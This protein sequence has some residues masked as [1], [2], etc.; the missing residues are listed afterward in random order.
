LLNVGRS[1]LASLGNEYRVIAPQPPLLVTDAEHCDYNTGERLMHVAYTFENLSLRR[2]LLPIWHM[3]H[4]IIK[5]RLSQLG[6]LPTLDIEFPPS[7][8]FGFR[9]HFS[10]VCSTT[11]VKLF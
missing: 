7:L 2:K 10:S 4:D 9:F 1:L 11:Q 6:L 3:T 8:D 5:H